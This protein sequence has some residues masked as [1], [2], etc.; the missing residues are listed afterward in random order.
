M[1]KAPPTTLS[2]RPTQMSAYDEETVRLERHGRQIARGSI[3]FTAI[4]RVL[5]FLSQFVYHVFPANDRIAVAAAAGNSLREFY[6]TKND[7][8][9]TQRLWSPTSMLWPTIF[10]LV[11]AVIILIFY[12]IILSAY[13]CGTAMADRWVKYESSYSNFANVVHTTFT[14]AVT[15]V[16][17]GTS[18]NPDSL[19]AQTCSP[20]ADAKQQFFPSVHLGR[21]CNQQVQSTVCVCVNCRYSCNI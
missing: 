6:N 18:T 9:G 10:A 15:G 16:L 11:T 5:N 12:G 3:I 17:F 1:D 21:I 2:N 8:N 4:V 13:C 20:A 14:T 19:N 7:T